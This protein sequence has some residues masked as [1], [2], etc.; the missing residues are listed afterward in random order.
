MDK[1][2]SAV[3]GEGDGEEGLRFDSFRFNVFKLIKD[4][5]IERNF[6]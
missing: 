3:V 6:N 4:L 2:D 1:K 5:V